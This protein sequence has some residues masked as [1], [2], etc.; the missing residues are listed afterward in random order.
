MGQI[1]NGIEAVYRDEVD[2]L[3]TWC[4]ENNPTLNV[5]ETKEI[6]VDFRRHKGDPSPLTSIGKEIKF[7]FL[8]TYII[9]D[10]KWAENTTA[11]VKKAHQ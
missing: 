4:T 9:T 7:K 11:I 10:L 5:R 3:V 6:I 2:K 1:S 8:A